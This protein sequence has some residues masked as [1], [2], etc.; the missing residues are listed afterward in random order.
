MEIFNES[1][2][3]F[4]LNRSLEAK[5]QRHDKEDEGRLSQPLAMT[6]E[7]QPIVLDG[8]DKKQ[9]QQ[10]LRVNKETFWQLKSILKQDC[11]RNASK[12]APL[13][14]VINLDVNFLYR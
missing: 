2:Q 6:S 5:C 1:E 12:N 10:L 3:H 8:K 13:V 9:M 4:L 7:G 14:N 11:Q